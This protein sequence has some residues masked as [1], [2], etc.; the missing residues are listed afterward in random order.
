MQ[1]IAKANC[2]LDGF[3]P[4]RKLDCGWFIQLRGT[5]PNTGEPIDE[6]GCAMAWQP[7]LMIETA[8]QQRQT[9]AALESLRNLLAHRPLAQSD[10]RYPAP[11]QEID[12]CD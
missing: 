12:T 9:G 11:L 8:Q 5:H 6:W 10:Q 1:I 3:A 4:C 7:I 2:P